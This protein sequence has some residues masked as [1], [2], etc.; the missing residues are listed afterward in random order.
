[1]IRSEKCCDNEDWNGLYQYSSQIMSV[2]IRTFDFPSVF[3]SHYLSTDN[4]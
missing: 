3:M 2:K 4:Q 1:L